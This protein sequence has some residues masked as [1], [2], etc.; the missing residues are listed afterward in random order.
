[1]GRLGRALIMNREGKGQPAWFRRVVQEPGAQL[2]GQPCIVRNRQHQL[3]LKR[4]RCHLFP[5]I[6]PLGRIE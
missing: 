3:P 2:F 6:E 5:E 1:M 4:K